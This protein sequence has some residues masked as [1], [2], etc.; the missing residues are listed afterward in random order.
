MFYR[1]ISHSNVNF[2]QIMAYIFTNF[3]MILCLRT[4]LEA[5]IPEGIEG[6]R[7][8]FLFNKK[9]ILAPSI[10]SGIVAP[11]LAL[12]VIILLSCHEL[13]NPPFFI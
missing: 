12:H 8:P 13:L 7:I 4:S 10:L 11:K 1:S 3:A 2:Y 6:A 9:G 5:K